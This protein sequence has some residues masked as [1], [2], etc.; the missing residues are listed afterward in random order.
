MAPPP[1]LPPPPRALLLLLVALVALV[2]LPPTSALGVC[3]NDVAS[4]S[5]SHPYCGLPYVVGNFQSFFTCDDDAVA[6]APSRLA[7]AGGAWRAVAAGAGDGLTELQIAEAVRGASAVR[8]V[9][10]GHSWWRE[11]WCPVVPKS[12]GG[13]SST[14]ES[15][16][17][18]GGGAA[19]VV[20]VPLTT[21]AGVAAVSRGDIGATLKRVVVDKESMTVTC[22]AGLSQRALL[23]ALDHWDEIEEEGARMNK[24]GGNSSGSGGGSSEGRNRR[25]RNDPTG[26]TLEAFSWFVDQ[27]MGGAVATASHGSSLRQGGLSSQMRAARLV[28]AN[29]TTL[30]VRRPDAWP[31]AAE[32]SSS[33]AAR[34]EAFLWRAVAASTGRLGVLTE[35]TMDIAANERRVRGSVR[36][37]PREFAA[38]VAELSEGYKEALAAGGGGG[39]GSVNVNEAA[40]RAVR[41]WDERQ[42]FWFVPS[43]ALTVVKITREG[44]LSPAEFEDAQRAAG[45]VAPGGRGQGEG[46]APAP[47]VRELS[48]NGG[49]D[50][51]PLPPPTPTPPPR[52]ASYAATAMADNAAA[53][54]AASAQASQAT[55]VGRAS[56]SSSSS[57]SSAASNAAASNA[58]LLRALAPAG[59]L[60]AIERGPKLWSRAYELMLSANTFNSTLPARAAYIS[61]SELESSLHSAVNAYDQYEVA[62]PLE[63]AG[64]CLAK[65]NAALYGNASDGSDGDERQ[66]ARWRGFRAPMLIRFVAGERAFLSNSHGGPVMFANL[67]DHVSYALGGGQGRSFAERARAQKEADKAAERAASGKKPRAGDGRV[68]TPAAPLMRNPDFDAVMKVLRGNVCR[69]RLHWGKAGWPLYASMGASWPREEEGEGE[70]EGEGDAGGAGGEPQQ[71]D[72]LPPSCFDGAAEYGAAWCS[73]GCAVAELDPTGK[74]EPEAGADVGWWGAVV[75]GGGGEAVTTSGTA[76]RVGDSAFARLCCGADGFRSDQCRCARRSEAGGSATCRSVMM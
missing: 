8:A 37:T 51:L 66:Q 7:S 4:G 38:E 20:V 70:G 16:S 63:R 39:G 52:V 2:L 67:E 75:V 47:N 24:S 58:A 28:L 46:P 18:G 34:R 1:P 31:A 50:V 35:V 13:S 33:P 11:G 62:V 6:A 72:P 26:L 17:S 5:A 40:W 23:R 15:G 41:A 9:G 74:F 32:G 59:P 44:G 19:A 27:T 68:G 64:D 30:A 49:G 42:A 3:P 69:G 71:E 45:L 61:C 43:Q 12:S 57:S 22:P 25:R 36:R 65:L 48:A 10:L 54:A 14:N 73:F 76:G 21:Q 53:E 29:G 60:P 56:P 55:A